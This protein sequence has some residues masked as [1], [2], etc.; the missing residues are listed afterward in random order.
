[1][2]QSRRRITV[3]VTPQTL[4]HLQN[5]ADACHRGDVGRAVDDLV[6][7]YQL[8]AKINKPKKV[9]GVYHVWK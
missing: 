8:A 4:Y 5:L 2:K 1:V 3:A 7:E 9:E 6:R